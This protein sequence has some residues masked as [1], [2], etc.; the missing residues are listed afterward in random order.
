[1]ATVYQ[2][3]DLK[4]HRRVALKLLHPDLNSALGPERFLREIAVASRL[5]HPHILPLHDSGEAEGRLFYAMPYVEGE[6]LRQRLEREPQLPVDEADR[7]LQA[8]ASALD[9]AHRAGVVHRDIKPE[10]ILLARDPGGGPD[11][12]LV[13]DFGLACALDVAGGERLTATGMALGTP[14]YMSPEQATASQGIDGRTD[15]YALGCVAYE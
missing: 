12:P 15:I 7:V 13:A 11:R 2:A 14:G 8:V 4:L 10:N 1:M 9:Y 5:N 3:E 6:S